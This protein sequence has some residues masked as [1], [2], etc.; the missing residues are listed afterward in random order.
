MALSVILSQTGGVIEG[1]EAV[2]KSYPGFFDD[3]KALGAS[4]DITENAL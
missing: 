1:A 3:L 2:R 4:V